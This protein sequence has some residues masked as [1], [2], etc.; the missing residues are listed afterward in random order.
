VTERVEQLDRAEDDAARATADGQRRMSDVLGAMRE[1]TVSSVRAALGW[2]EA[3]LRPAGGV[4]AIPVGERARR[5]GVPGDVIHAQ[6]GHA[7][8]VSPAAGGWPSL[9]VSGAVQALPGGALRLYLQVQ[10]ERQ[11]SRGAIDRELKLEH[12]VT[13]PDADGANAVQAMSELLSP[14]MNELLPNFRTELASP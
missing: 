9:V 11:R 10:V 7:V 13:A 14:V 12:N 6:A 1:L 2:P 5:A 8:A 3:Q 4:G